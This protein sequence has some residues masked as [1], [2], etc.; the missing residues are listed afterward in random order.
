MKLFVSSLDP[1]SD[2]FVSDDWDEL[3]LFVLSWLEVGAISQCRLD[4]VFEADA[5]DSGLSS[6]EVVGVHEIIHFRVWDE[7]EG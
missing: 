4:F 6:S 1:I 3:Y 7:A 5:E 2:V